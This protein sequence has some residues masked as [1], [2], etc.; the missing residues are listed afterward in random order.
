[1]G[2]AGRGCAATGRG[3]SWSEASPWRGSARPRT[4]CSEQDVLRTALPASIQFGGLSGLIQ[5]NLQ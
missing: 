5:A 4:R 3:S 1:M 2:C